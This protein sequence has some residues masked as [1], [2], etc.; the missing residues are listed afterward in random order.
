MRI[1]VVFNPIAGSGRGERL[2]HL[3][4]EALHGVRLST[5][6]VLEFVLE[7]SRLEPPSDWLDPLVDGVDLMVVGGG[8]GAM[9]LAATTA[10]RTGTVVYHYPAGTE[11]L[12]SR[13]HGMLADPE[14]LRSALER[15]V[16]RDLDVFRVNGELGLLFAS[17]GFDAEVVDDLARHR[18]GS[19]RHASYLLPIIRQVLQWT[20]R[21]SRISVQ[22]DGESIGEAVSG[23]ALVANS[24]QYAL[25]LNPS[26]ESIPD[27]GVL[28]AVVLPARTVFGLLRW[29]LR[30]RWGRTAAARRARGRSIDL[31]LEPP[32]HLQI[33]GDRPGSAAP[34][35]R[36]EV[37]IEPGALRVLCPPSENHAS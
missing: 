8:G 29:A 21:R 2:A 23:L 3:L 15:G 13:D 36:Y 31:K 12:F 27:D 26:S 34:S 22:V 17:V 19:I 4:F 33:D 25:R 14:T 16:R 24:P 18:R 28:E 37:R 6:S 32:G 20:R 9:R 11:N 30:C 5:G 1:L 10:I 35:N 7:P